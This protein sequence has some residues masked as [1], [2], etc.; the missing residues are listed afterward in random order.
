M[1]LRDAPKLYLNENLSPRLAEQLRAQ[2]V[3]VVASHEARMLAVSDDAQLAFAES[4]RR[5]IVTFNIHD[6]ANLHAEYS[7]NAVS[8]WGMIFST[9]EPIGAYSA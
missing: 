8:H 1:P 5:A 9:E 3:D 6:F 7:A 4:E 2:G